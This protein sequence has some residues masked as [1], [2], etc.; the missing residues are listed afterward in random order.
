MENI[1]SAGAIQV[2]L[3]VITSALAVFKIL[4]VVRKKNIATAIYHTYHIV[5]DIAAAD[6]SENGIDKTA[7]ALKT[8]DQWMAAQ[9]WRPLKPG[10]QALAKMAWSSMHAQDGAATNP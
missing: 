2:I 9:G 6:K 10:E 3:G 7:A 4:N 5:E 1:F 8:I